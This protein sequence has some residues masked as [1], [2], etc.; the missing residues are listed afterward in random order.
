MPIATSVAFLSARSGQ[1]H[2][3]LWEHEADPK[4]VCGEPC[5]NGCSYC[6]E[7]FRR[8]DV[9]ILRRRSIQTA[10]LPANVRTVSA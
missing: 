1:C 8:S 7:H 5:L 6:Q 4:L 2:W 3:P 9:K 10:G